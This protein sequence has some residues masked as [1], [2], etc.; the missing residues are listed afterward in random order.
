MGVVTV[1]VCG[2]RVL[3]FDVSSSRRLE[4]FVS[5]DLDGLLTWRFGLKKLL[6]LVFKV[7]FGWVL[8][9]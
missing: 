4:L 1:G 6:L 8:V 7:G 5:F 2:C 9:V 3:M